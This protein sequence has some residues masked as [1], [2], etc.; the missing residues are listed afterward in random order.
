MAST[1]SGL[2]VF[3]GFDY[4]QRKTLPLSLG[5]PSSGTQSLDDYPLSSSSSAYSVCVLIIKATA[6]TIQF[7]LLLVKR[8]IWQW[9]I[10]YI[11]KRARVDQSPV[12]GQKWARKSGI[13]TRNR[14]SKLGLNWWQGGSSLVI[15]MAVASSLLDRLRFTLPHLVH[16]GF[17][18][19]VQA[20]NKGPS[21]V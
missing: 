19:H 15:L 6:F 18:Q 11:S 8:L 16:R 3:G 9:V 4:T 21:S 2:I 17:A 20:P 5:L 13:W 1:L 12:E 7:P 14:V 10:I